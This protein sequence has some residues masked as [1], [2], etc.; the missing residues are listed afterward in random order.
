MHVLIGCEFS[1]IVREA[2]IASGHDAWSCD[3]LPT[4]IPGQHLQEDV[5]DVLDFGWDMAIFH[6][7]CTYLAV[8]GAR[9]MK[10]QDARKSGVLVG[11][12]RR[13]AQQQAIEFFLKL[14]NCKI[15]KKAIENPIGCMSSVFRKPDQIIK[16]SWFGH[17]EQ[18]L[19]CLWLEGL[20]AL[21]PTNTVKEAPRM[22]L[23]S[24]KSL[25]EWYGKPK[26]GE[27]RQKARNRTFLGIAEAMAEQWGKNEQVEKSSVCVRP[28]G[29][30]G[31]RGTLLQKTQTT[32]F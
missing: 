15:P 19:T 3:L 8:S 13:D 12:A 14:Y 7:P 1:G 4:E 26:A 23:R 28:A 27:D 9:W 5:L 21:T 2:F 20:P 10:D 24:G 25:P 29:M 16:P 30:P 6:P 31:L 22:I 32:L 17:P 18:K 11:A